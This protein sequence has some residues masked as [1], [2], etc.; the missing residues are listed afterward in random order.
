MAEAT[1]NQFPNIE[2]QLVDFGVVGHLDARRQVLGEIHNQH[3]P[4]R[5][6]QRERSL[7]TK[8]GP[9]PRRAL[10]FIGNRRW[11]A[12][13]RGGQTCHTAQVRHTPRSCS[14]DPR[15]YHVSVLGS[16]RNTIEALSAKQCTWK[17]CAPSG[18]IFNKR[19]RCRRCGTSTFSVFGLTTKPFPTRKAKIHDR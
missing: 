8:V 2:T 17:S 6:S 15:P 19:R 14:T 11:F 7:E 12:N 5:E 9:G 4:I 18:G 13:A 10:N 3:T 16:N 1:K